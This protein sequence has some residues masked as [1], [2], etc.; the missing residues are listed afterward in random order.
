MDVWIFIDLKKTFDTH[1]LHKL[2]HY[3]VSGAPLK[4]IEPYLTNKRPYLFDDRV[5][6][7]ILPITFGVSQGSVFGPL[8]F[9]IYINDLL[10]HPQRT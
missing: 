10:N 2:E 7:K 9:L 5:T 3:G 1:L 8:L 4:L 6:S